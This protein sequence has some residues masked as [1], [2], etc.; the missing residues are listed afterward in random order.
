MLV[1]I[2]RTSSLWIFVSFL[3]SSLYCLPYFFL[4]SAFNVAC[5]FLVKMFLG[6]GLNLKSLSSL[7]FSI[8]SSQSPIKLKI[9][10]ERFSLS[11][12]P[13]FLTPKMHMQ[14]PNWSH[15][16]SVLPSVISCLAVFLN[17]YLTSL[18]CI[19]FVLDMY[20]ANL[21]ALIP[22]FLGPAAPPVISQ[23]SLI[24]I[25]QKLQ[26]SFAVLPSPSFSQ[27]ANTSPAGDHLKSVTFSLGWNPINLTSK[28]V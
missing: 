26:I 5:S 28:P 11:N 2:A 13:G 15:S 1:F 23:L 12:G 4:N 14:R 20:F 9:L 21:V 27:M 8:A 24:T 18:A 6:R 10:I 7:S 3:S 17:S 16:A 25:K 22:S 19:E